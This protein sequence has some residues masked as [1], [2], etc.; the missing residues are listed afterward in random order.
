MMG[1]LIERGELRRMVLG[2][3]REHGPCTTGQ[4]R[5]AIGVGLDQIGNVL[6]RLRN[7]GMA[8]REKVQGRG[9]WRWAATCMEGDKGERA[10]IVKRDKWIGHAR[11]PWHRLF[12]GEAG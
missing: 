10:L 6:T 12:F 1:E 7:D 4:I 8:E 11:D 3:V 2:F 5:D 9:A